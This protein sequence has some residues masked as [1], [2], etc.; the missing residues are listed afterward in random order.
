MVLKMV[1]IWQDG[2]GKILYKIYGLILHLY[3]IE[4]GLILTTIIIVIYVKEGNMIEFTQSLSTSLTLYNTAMKSIIFVVTI[5]R[6]KNLMENLKELLEF[7]DFK[8]TRRPLVIKYEATVMKITKY[9]A[10]FHFAIC[11]LSMIMAVTSSDRRLP[12]KTYS[13]FD[14]KNDDNAYMF[15][16]C[17]IYFMSLYVTGIN[18]MLDVYPVIFMCYIIAF[19]EELG[20]YLAA[21][22]F[23]EKL[24]KRNEFSYSTAIEKL[25]IYAGKFQKYQVDSFR[26]RDPNTMVD[27][28]TCVNFHVRIKQFCDKVSKS[29]ALHFMA[30]GLFSSLILCSTIFHLTK[31]SS[32]QANYWMDLIKMS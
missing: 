21:V 29:Y 22:E 17:A 6:I 2:T 16:N 7:S 20:G 8:S 28:E 14:Y 12:F 4:Q 18:G 13:Y 9:N 1:G 23:R 32:L 15:M 26:K 24:R 25:Y 19:I 3:F 11:T 30:Q 5:N 10:Y 31:V 27:L